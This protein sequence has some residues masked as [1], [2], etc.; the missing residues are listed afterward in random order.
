MRPAISLFLLP[1][2]AWFGTLQ[3]LQPIVPAD[4]FKF[5]SLATLLSTLTVL[6][7]RLGVW[8]QEMEN[9]KDNV[10]AELK[11]YREESSASFAGLN[12]HLEAIDHL[13][14]AATERSE[15]VIRWQRRTERRLERL[16]IATSEASR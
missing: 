15:R 8:R 4:P 14:T 5:V 11:A 10:G 1:F 12:R 2:A 6:V 3:S 9:T 13:M 16:E 7:Y